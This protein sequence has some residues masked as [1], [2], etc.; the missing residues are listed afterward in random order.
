MRVD[1]PS[2]LSERVEFTDALTRLVADQVASN[3]FAFDATL[4]GAA[5]QPEASVRLGWTDVDPAARELIPAID[6]LRE[7]FAAQGV[8]RFVLCGMGG[9][10]LGPA[11]IAQ[12]AGIELTMLDSTDPAAVARALEGDLSRTAV[13]VS[14]KSG[15]TIETRSH[16]DTF[17]QAFTD[18]GITPSER[19]VIVTDPGSPLEQ[20]SRAADRHVFLADP[21]VGGRFSVLTA[22]GLVPAGLAGADI[23]G[24]VAAGTAVRDELALNTPTNP[25]LRLAAAIYA[26]LPA[27]FVLAVNEDASARW[28][29]GRWAEQLVA[30]ST[31]KDGLGVLPIALPD[32]APEFDRVPASAVVVRVTA[33]AGAAGAADA[34]ADAGSGSQ[35]LTVAGNLGAQFLLWEVATAALGRLMGIDPFNQPD[36][37]SAKIAARAALAELDG[38]EAAT[39]VTAAGDVTVLAAP[40]GA[41]A[42]TAAEIAATLREITPR[43]GYLAVQAYVDPAGELREPL[44]RLRTVLARE[45]GVP[46]SLGYG[47]SYLHSVGQLHKGG[48]AQGAFLQIS[49]PGEEDLA[50]AQSETSFGTLI[51][52]QAR[53]DRGVLIERGR[54][55]LA[56]ALAQRDTSVLEQLITEFTAA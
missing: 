40:A 4:W 31:G 13:I 9:S 46:V 49:D 10:S 16:L 45:L 23:A 44:E 6:E 14:S 48:P 39:T 28:G 36:V 51:S 27:R 18:A 34:A 38:T 54:P 19:V 11:V 32:D 24:L 52:A 15:S 29:L 2:E 53:G 21:N 37:E 20:Q 5:A 33:D 47:P 3:I 7:A 26:G 30:E 8:N 55:V 50:I 42:N 12:W 17:E 35:G 22:F 43:D 41:A 1:L 56:I 25:A